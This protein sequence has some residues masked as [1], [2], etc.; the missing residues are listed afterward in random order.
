MATKN[1][2]FYSAKFNRPDTIK[3][4]RSKRAAI[5]AAGDFG[6]IFETESEKEFHVH[7]MANNTLSAF[8]EGSNQYENMNFKFKS[9]LESEHLI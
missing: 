4:H 5:N 7:T 8:V 1:A 3:S 6:M 2:P 9:A